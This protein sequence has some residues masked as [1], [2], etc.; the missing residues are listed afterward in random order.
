MTG[1]NPNWE[2]EVVG[3]EDVVGAT[4]VF[5]AF[6]HFFKWFFN[7]DG[8]GCVADWDV[9]AVA[10]LNVLQYFDPG[11]D[12]PAESGGL[13]LIFVVEDVVITD[14]EGKL[15]SCGAIDAA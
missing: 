10:Q 15:R 1:A 3:E 6:L 7:F 9:V 14:V 4:L 12:I 8:L 13:Q 2:S 5:H 11:T